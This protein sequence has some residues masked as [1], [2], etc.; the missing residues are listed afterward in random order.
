MEEEVEEEVSSVVVGKF[1]A[2]ASG[3]ASTLEKEC[4]CV[5]DEMEAE[6]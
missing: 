6:S 2:D 3:V 5:V 4:C 1:S